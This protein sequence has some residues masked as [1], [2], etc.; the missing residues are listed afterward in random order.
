MEQ[1][2]ILQY[3]DPRLYTVA[4]PVAA[5]DERVRALVARA[6]LPTHPPA[7]LGVDRFLDLMAVDKK[8][9]GGRLRLV[10]LRDIGE[11]V[12]TD[13]FDPGLLRATLEAG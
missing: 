12:L 7:S 6:G 10:L 9:R 1:L 2:T 8:V 3:P 4:K 11:A 5:V 13:E